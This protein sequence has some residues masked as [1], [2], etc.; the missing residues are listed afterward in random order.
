MHIRRAYLH[1][2][3]V[4]IDHDL[5]PYAQALAAVEAIETASLS[6]AALAERA[7]AAREAAASGRPLDD[8]LPEVFALVREA[9]ARL[10]GLRPFD[11]Q[12]EAAVALHRGRLAQLATGEG[13]T[14]VAVMPAVLNALTGRGVHVFT[15][16]DYLAERDAG[17]MGPV[18]R[19]FGLTP[20]FVGQR[21]SREERR[22]AYAAD[23]TYVTAKEAGFDFLR[24][25]TAAG[26]ADLVQR[27]PHFAIVDEADFI[28]I[29]EAR[30]PLVIAGAAPDAG[31]DHRAVAEAAEALVAGRDFDADEY[32][33]T[34]VLTEAGFAH[35][36]RLLGA[37]LTSPDRR[38]LLSA[39]HVALHARVLLHRDRDYIVRDG[40]IELVDEFT[41]RV[42]DNRRWPHGI[43]SAVEAKEG[44]AVSAEGRI[45]GSIPIQHFVRR[46]PRLAG[47]TATAEPAA[48]EFDEFYGLRTVVFPPHK[49]GV[50]RDEDDEVFTHREAKNAAIVAEI[51][52]VHATG[53]PVLVGTASVAESEALA[54][55]LSAA[56]VP[57]QVLNARHDA[58]EAAIVATAGTTG[59]VT[60]STNM[61]GRGTDIVLGAG[62]PADRARVE[63]LGG[64]YVVGTN[65]HESRRVDDQLRGRSGRQGDPGSSRFFISI[66]DDLIK[67][68]GVMS[69]IPPRHRP[70]RQD[71]PLRDPV[72]VCEIARAQRIIEGQNFEIRRT[73]WRY[74]EMVDDQRRMVYERR[75]AFLRDEADPDVC[76]ARAPEQYAALVRAAG[77]AAVR[78]AEQRLIVRALDQAWTD[79]LAFV[80]DVREGIHLQRYGGKDP[81]TEF[82]RQ[83]IEAFDAMMHRVEDETIG[84]FARLRA[85]EE[86][87]DFSGIGPSRSSATWTYLVDDNPFSPLGSSLLASRTLATAAGILGVIYWPVTLVTAITIFWRRWSKKRKGGRQVER[88]EQ[89]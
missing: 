13:K 20:S 29:D 81:L 8:L 37:D 58:R 4:P 21:L 66:E 70:A 83:L 65:R 78:R 38:L 1:A 18:Y 64:L 23:V 67:R 60:I 27:P 68:Y 89:G 47:M 12:V 54:E 79:H 75:Q 30:V 88:G 14:L 43:H 62:D 69:L 35:A 55:A 84:L 76:R 3:G 72:V 6:D 44:L 87:I 19:F 73:L 61:A 26:P 32:E 51:A 41:G 86:G 22:R 77:E 53:R 2:A 5:K 31:V 7:T 46:Y 33:R 85:S 59:A 82:S 74:S 25:H 50:R 52:E 17:W 24:D 40:R 57:C 39:L 10:L 56:G 9:S 63:A 49:S 16:N 45:L 28:L 11:V 71:G 42:A 34:V 36:S 80:E 48:Q 15:A